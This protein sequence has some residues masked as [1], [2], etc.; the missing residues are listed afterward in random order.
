MNTQLTDGPTPA[1]GSQN[2]NRSAEIHSLGR[3]EMPTVQPKYIMVE[4]AEREPF[5]RNAEPRGTR[6]ANHSAEMQSFEEHEMQ[7][8]EQKCI[9]LGNRKCEPL[10][11]NASWLGTQHVN[12][13]AEMHHSRNHK[14]P[15]IRQKCRARGS[16]RAY[17]NRPC[18]I[19]AAWSRDEVWL[20]FLFLK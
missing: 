12:R 1:S 13:S 14:M 7:T 4:D 3:H 11:R 20:K 2:A 8:I 6:N 10:S 15:T 19:L 17:H 16:H 5:G 18:R 9:M